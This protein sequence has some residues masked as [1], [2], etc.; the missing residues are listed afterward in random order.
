MS[1]GVD[2]LAVLA[3]EVDKALNG[4][5]FGDVEFHGGFADV[6]VDLA[7]CTA[8]VAEIGIC[9]FAGAIDDAAHDSDTNALEVASGGADFLG[10]GLEVEKGATAGRAGDVI[11]LEDAR[12]GGLENVVGKAEGLAGSGFSTHKD[13]IADAVT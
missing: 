11:G 10:G 6:E 12:A 2:P 7:G 9:H 13:G 3:D 8:D 5:G 4:F 1:R